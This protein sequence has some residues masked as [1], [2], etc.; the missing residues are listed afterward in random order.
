MSS[1]RVIVCIVFGKIESRLFTGTGSYPKTTAG[2][3]LGDPRERRKQR[4]AY[5]EKE[6]K[7]P[8]K[9]SSTVF[10]ERHF[11]FLACVIRLI[12]SR[13]TKSWRSRATRTNLVKLIS[14]I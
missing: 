8:G 1:Y 4:R 3:C 14:I 12:M 5:R 11:T 6:E 9:L 7:K 2:S 13:W 10:Q